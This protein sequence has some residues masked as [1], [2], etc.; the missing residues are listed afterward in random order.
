M[1]IEKVLTSI[2][3]NDLSANYLIYGEEDFFIDKIANTFINNV[4]PESEKIF[5]QKNILW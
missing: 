1:S 3:N 5:N 4:I 2:K